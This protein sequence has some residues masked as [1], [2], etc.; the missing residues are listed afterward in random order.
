MDKVKSES[1]GVTTLPQP[2]TDLMIKRYAFAIIFILIGIAVSICAKNIAGLIVA[3]PA[4]YLAYLAYTVRQDYTKGRI[5]ECDA[6]CLSVRDKNV[7]HFLQ[8]SYTAVFEAANGAVA[9]FE[10]PGRKYKKFE[11][12]IAYRIYFHANYDST[13]L[14]SGGPIGSEMDFK[15]WQETENCRE[16]GDLNE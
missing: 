13:I 3:F 7:L 2:L 10:M 8:N 12:G 6:L 11:A 4:L 15:T 5:I 14:A 1:S 9:E 16:N